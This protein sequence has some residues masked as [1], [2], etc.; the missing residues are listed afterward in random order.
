MKLK[1]FHITT[2]IILIWNFSFSQ[3][4]INYTSN[5]GLPSNH[6]YR[7]TQDH[8]GFI[9]VIT[10]TGI[11][12]FDGTKFKTFTTRDGMPTND[13]WDIA[14]TPDDRVWFFSKSPMLGYIENDKVYAFPTENDNDIL[15][16]TSISQYGNS[17][18]FGY[19]ENW[20]YL[21]DS[22]WQ[23]F[24]ETAGSSTKLEPVGKQM[25]RLTS[26]QLKNVFHKNKE[27]MA[28]YSGR[29][30]EILIIRNLDSLSFWLYKGGYGILNL[31]TKNMFRSE[32]HKKYGLEFSGIER[33]HFVNNQIQITG[34]NYVARLGKD[35]QIESPVLFPKELQSHFSM[36]D[37]SGNIWLATFNNGIYMLPQVRR[38]IAYSLPNE[39]VT[40]LVQIDDKLMV[41][42][43]DK[44]FYQFDKNSTAFMPV[45]EQ[46]GYANRAVKIDSLHKSYFISESRIVQFQKNSTPITL[47]NSKENRNDVARDLVYYKGY[48]YGNV[49]T[50]L[51]KL[52][53]ETLRIINQYHLVGIT[54][55]ISFNDCII[56]ATT[57][58]L[59][60]F[61]NDSIQPIP[62]LDL[63]LQ[64]PVSNL[65]K[66]NDST[67]LVM[68]N[69]YGTF[70]T[71]L[72]ESSLLPGSEYS[73]AQD[74]Y[75]ENDTIWIA[76]ENG[77][78]RYQKNGNNYLI[79]KRYGPSDGLPSKMSNTVAIFNNQIIVGTDNGIAVFS[80]TLQ[81]KP[82]LLDIFIEKANYNHQPMTANTNSFEYTAENNINFEVFSLD[83]SVG[84]TEFTY[85]YKLTPLQHDWNSTSSASL[86]FTNLSPD[87]YTLFVKTGKFQKEIA[88]SIMPLWWQRTWTQLV[89]VAGGL[90]MLWL[91]LFQFKKKELTRKT[92]KLSAQKKLAEYELYA[93]R[94]QMNPHFVFNSLAAIQ[95]YIN[96][97]DFETSEKYLIKFS[98]LIRQFF[99]L[100]KQEE[101]TVNDEIALLK[102]YLDIE[103]LRFKEK[104]TYSILLDNQINAET[105]TIPCMLLQPIVENAVNHG[106]FNKKTDGKI[107]IDFKI[108]DEGIII[109]ITDDGVGFANSKKNSTRAI[110]S[111][112][113]LAERIKIIN[114]SDRW[115][116][117][118]TT[119]EA[120]PKRA[121]KGNISKFIIKRKK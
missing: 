77:V 78:M 60:M 99:E 74:A 110:N 18:V 121:N 76:S 48:L 7:I 101:I 69:G 89:F 87:D 35:F 92:A 49:A 85:D 108:M 81:K 9:W 28:L 47:V 23:L 68:T 111:S 38:T 14:I 26:N 65:K 46:K 44:G 34:N 53:P 102:N 115:N 70:I 63:R 82:Q 88:F 75:I 57:R 55:I 100:S 5:D 109:E 16:P 51:N 4:F 64:K 15:Y 91:V 40:D 67:L 94:S 95:F 22:C 3:Q 30:E 107:A 98:K 93:L 2:F 97:N 11:A 41:S 20:Y 52:H 37:K 10:D 103:K 90:I 79:M 19:N 21:E 114:E 117:I 84:S 29:N 42:V 86:N 113:V 96:E 36:I 1:K 104:L 43:F 31:N 50:V 45:M 54:K 62:S 13:I 6:V 17:V 8:K 119:A 112:N 33:F 32:F 116:I 58:G 25:T 59:K 120:F 71:N 106:I 12:K 61:K 56:I 39:K 118:Y 105:T 24:K 72:K 73:S 27:T 66:V 83:F 80:K